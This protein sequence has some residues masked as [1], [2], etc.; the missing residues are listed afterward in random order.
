MIVQN[1]G[2]KSNIKG[3]IWLLTAC[4]TKIFVNPSL[5]YVTTIHIDFIRIH[6]SIL[7]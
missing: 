4:I 3:W 5:M 6:I 1:S 7:V 2:N